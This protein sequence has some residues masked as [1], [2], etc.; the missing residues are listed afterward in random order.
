MEKD[1]V[2]MAVTALKEGTVIDH[3]PAGK[4][5]KVVDIMN[6]YEYKKTLR[7]GMY[8]N[9]KTYG[10]K[11]LL[12]IEDR[13]LTQEEANRIAL[14]APNATINIIKDW[15]VAKKIKVSLPDVITGLKC[16]NPRCITRH[17]HIKTKFIVMDKKTLKV[18]CHYCEHVFEKEEII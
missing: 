3:I 10:K 17:D 9:S 16:A 1:D 14:I 12:K 4:L 7:M 5:F 15:K 6:L 8:L 18:R 2:K 11:D 13:Y